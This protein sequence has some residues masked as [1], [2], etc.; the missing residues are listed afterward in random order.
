MTLAKS[1]SALALAAALGGCSSFTHFHSPRT[2]PERGG[3]ATINAL[4]PVDFSVRVGVAR[5]WDAGLRFTR[6]GAGFTEVHADVQRDVDPGGEGRTAAFGFGVG[7]STAMHEWVLNADGGTAW[8][9]QPYAS[10][11]DER[12]YAAVRPNLV[13]SRSDG[14]VGW[15]PI[16]TAGTVRGDRVKLVPE[17]NLVGLT[18]P[19]LGLGVQYR[20]GELWKP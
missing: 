4:I 13:V 1:L 8:V 2:L 12:A 16:L 6:P 17:L 19:T 11:G 3:S 7:L 20:D 10:F 15:L 18:L 9:L 14:R 5:G